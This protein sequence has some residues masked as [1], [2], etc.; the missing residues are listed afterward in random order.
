MKL[1]KTRNCKKRVDITKLSEKSLEA[2]AGSSILERGKKY[3]KSGRVLYITILENKIKSEVQ[4]SERYKVKIT[5][6]KFRIISDHF[7]D[8]P[9]DGHCCKHVI[10][11][12]Y[13]IMINNKKYFSSNEID[14]QI[15]KNKK[16][17]LESISLEDIKKN[18]TIKVIQD[19]FELCKHVKIRN[20]SNN[21]FTAT[22]SAEREYTLTLKL[23]EKND[24]GGSSILEA[25][26]SCLHYSY[27]FC[28]H[29][30]AA[31][32]TS[33]IKNGQEQSVNSFKEN[34]NNSYNLQ[35]LNLF[36]QQMDSLGLDSSLQD[37]KD[38]FL[39][40][41]LQ[42]V[43][44][45]ECTLFIQKSYTLRSNQQAVGSSI[46]KQFLEK[47]KDFFPP[48]QKKIVEKSDEFSQIAAVYKFV[49]NGPNGGTWIVD[50]RK[51][52]LGVRED[53][54]EA[55]CTVSMSDENFVKLVTGELKAE[56]AFMTGKLKLYGDMGLA[57]KLGKLFG[58]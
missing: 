20:K 3:Y 2:L 48:L 8:C 56:T 38:Y 40:F 4:G 32:F 58:K 27:S 41:N 19:S 10:A 54:S 16:T 29:T 39:I 33:L 28:I 42:I 1:F 35:L 34:I 6:N 46:S 30:L 25:K 55:K 21:S 12:L 57:I 31:I 9:Y 18:Y 5:L 44:S 53:N 37:V 23:V 15:K 26:C 24:Y 50:L 36:N 22:I 13:E 43:S 45:Q 51:D 49:L 17:L 52:T 47:N 11:V 14:P 7:C